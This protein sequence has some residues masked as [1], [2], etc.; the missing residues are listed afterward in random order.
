MKK[1]SGV[2]LFVSSLLV[3]AGGLVCLYRS[4]DT[5]TEG[6]RYKETRILTEE[7]TVEPE[8]LAESMTVQEAYAYLIRE[9][10]GFLAVYGSDG[11]TFLFETNVRVD[12]L[13]PA[14]QEKAARGIPVG[15]ERELYDFLESYSS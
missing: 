13:E 10:D 7:E 12:S 2:C 9:K 15:D 3:C 5:E 1:T 14:M 4:G 6:R 11:V 8:E